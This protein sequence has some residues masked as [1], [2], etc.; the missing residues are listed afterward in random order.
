MYVLLLAITLQMAQT[1]WFLVPISLFS[2]KK[3]LWLPK[4]KKN[5]FWHAAASSNVL[6]LHDQRTVVVF[7]GQPEK[8]TV[9]IGDAAAFLVKIQE[10]V[11]ASVYKYE[12][13]PRSEHCYPYL[14]TYTT[15]LL[16]ISKHLDWLPIPHTLYLVMT[17][18][19]L[20]I[21]YIW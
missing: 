15:S 21:V 3:I 19:V 6:L 5:I 18:F 14:A 1:L 13:C 8:K 10:I 4:L 9:K 12:I 16:K 20:Y 17:V 7:L 2:K 11:V